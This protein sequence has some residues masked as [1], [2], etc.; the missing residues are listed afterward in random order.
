MNKTTYG[1]DW[2]NI[3]LNSSERSLDIIDNLS[4]ED[5]LMEINCN[6]K[7]INE[8][9]VREQ[10]EKDLHYR[11]NC[12]RGVFE[13]NLRNIVQCAQSQKKYI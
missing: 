10:F 6:I 8:Q 4:F 1:T 5:L 3:D 9:T 11:I 12:A 13:H 7:D 2:T